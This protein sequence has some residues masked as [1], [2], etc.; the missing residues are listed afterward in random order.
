MNYE[1]FR[2]RITELAAKVEQLSVQD[3]QQWN[4]AK[5]ANE[6]DALMMVYPDHHARF[7]TELCAKESREREWEL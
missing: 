2:E 5:A 1:Q 3:Y 4:A 7:A 6:M